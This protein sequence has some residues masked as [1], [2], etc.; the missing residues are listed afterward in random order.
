[1]R[2][3]NKGL[4]LLSFETETAW[5]A[6]NELFEEIFCPLLIIFFDIILSDY[7]EIIYIFAA[8]RLRMCSRSFRLA[9]PRTTVL[10]HEQSTKLRNYY[11]NIY[12]S[13]PRTKG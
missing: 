13:S 8:E 11:D 6:C 3:Y 2:V 1:M 9:C 10:L 12:Q 7:S 5:D 4:C